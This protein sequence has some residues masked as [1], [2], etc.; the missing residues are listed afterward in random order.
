VSRRGRWSIAALAV[1]ACAAP[2]SAIGQADRK[3]DNLAVAITE[4]DGGRAFDFS[5]EVIRQRRGAVDS[6]NV[7]NAAARC[8][9]CRATAIAFQVVLAW[10]ADGVTPH[11]QAVAINDQCTRCVVYAGARQF[12]RVVDGPARFTGEGRS[13]LADV[14]N[15]LRALEGADLTVDEQIAVVEAQEARVLRVLVEEVVSKGDEGRVMVSDRD[16][17]E[18]DDD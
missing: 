18:A 8:T 12:V 4:Q 5:W 2:G 1:L 7:A 9:D 15:V 14:R 16:D 6:S 11:N 17:R 10:N 13:T 3:Q